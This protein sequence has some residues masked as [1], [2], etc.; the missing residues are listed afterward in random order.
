MTSF[1]MSLRRW[2]C[3]HIDVVHMRS[4]RHRRKFIFRLSSSPAF[5]ESDLWVRPAKL[6]RD[7][8]ER[9]LRLTFVHVTFP[10]EAGLDIWSDRCVHHLLLAANKTEATVTDAA[11]PMTWRA[12]TSPKYR[13][14]KLFGSSERTRKRPSSM[15]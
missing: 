2:H 1:N 7:G 3:R 6:G 15:S 5:A 10:S 8:R 11:V 9:W 14:S 4:A 13:L 12:S